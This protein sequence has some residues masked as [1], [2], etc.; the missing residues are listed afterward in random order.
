MYLNFTNSTFKD[1]IWVSGTKLKKILD[2][3][4]RKDVVSFT[5]EKDKLIFN[6]YNITAILE[7]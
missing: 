7:V 4:N 5:I 6:Y 1:T 2:T 3:M